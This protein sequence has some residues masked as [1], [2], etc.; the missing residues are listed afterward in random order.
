MVPV[1]LDT[2]VE[3]K[4]LLRHWARLYHYGH[5]YMPS[6]CVATVGLY[7][8]TALSKR[9][10]NNKQWL[11]YAAAAATTITMVP[12]T[13]AMMTSTNDALFQLE[14]QAWAPAMASTVDLRSVQEMVVRWTWL[15]VT[16]SI[17]PLIGA[18]LGFVAVLREVGQ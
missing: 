10:A 5:I 8:Y 7:A 2:D 15:H 4:Y 16:R 3:P 18:I 11:M 17:F 13:W 12:F 6:V 9:A 14:S 1:F